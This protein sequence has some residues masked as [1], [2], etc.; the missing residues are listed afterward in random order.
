MACLGLKSC[1]KP[2]S[3]IIL[4]SAAAEINTRERGFPGELR[5]RAENLRVLGSS[6]DGKLLIKR[7]ITPRDRD[8]CVKKA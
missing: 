4:M 7:H 5:N 8:F 2:E 3:L 6:L 1:L